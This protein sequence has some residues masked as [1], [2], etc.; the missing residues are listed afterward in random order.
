MERFAPTA[1]A[2]K[3]YKARQMAMEQMI[4][5][6]TFF[7]A[8][9]SSPPLLVIVVKPL[10]PRMPRATAPRKPKIPVYCGSTETLSNDQPVAHSPPMASTARPAILT[11]AMA[12]EKV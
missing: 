4:A 3:T 10:Y 1:R 6:P 12:N 2:T 5:R 8:S 9:F 11:K 7:E